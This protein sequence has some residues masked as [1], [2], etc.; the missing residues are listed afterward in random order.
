MTPTRF[1]NRNALSWPW[2]EILD[3]VPNLKD[4]PKI[5]ASLWDTERSGR[6]AVEELGNEHARALC[7]AVGNSDAFKSLL[8]APRTRILTATQRIAVGH[9]V[10]GRVHSP[11]P[12]A[13]DNP[14]ST[15][16]R[17]RIGDIMDLAKV[18]E[19]TLAEIDRKSVV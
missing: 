8:K 16:P 12:A 2:A 10:L 5:L 19:A 18:A 17:V 3:V 11:V 7:G 9:A 13:P 15:P 6:S 14:F 4:D 1:D